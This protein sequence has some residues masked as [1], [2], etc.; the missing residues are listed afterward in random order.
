[1]RPETLSVQEAAEFLGM[2]ESWIREAVAKRLLVCCK[3]G[4]KVRFLPEDLRA[5]ARAC[6]VV[7]A[8]VDGQR[9]PLYAAPDDE[10]TLEERVRKEFGRRHY[11]ALVGKQ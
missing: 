4:R 1:M 5:F 3:L 10:A 7:R 11:A 8:D 6:R 2:S 9:R